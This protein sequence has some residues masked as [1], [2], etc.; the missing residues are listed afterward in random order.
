MTN[1]PFEE[2]LLV[3]DYEDKRKNLSKSNLPRG[4]PSSLPPPPLP[5]SLLL[6]PPFH[7]PP[8]LL[9]PPPRA[10]NNYLL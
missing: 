2:V 9:L 1:A 3:I 7:P 5:L 8:L 10:A 4:V 6:P